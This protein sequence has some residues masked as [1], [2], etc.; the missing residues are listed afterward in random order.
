[1]TAQQL[2]FRQVVKTLTLED[3]KDNLNTIAARFLALWC[4]DSEAAK[5]SLDEMGVDGRLKHMLCVA[6]STVERRR[7]RQLDYEL[8]GM[9]I[10]HGRR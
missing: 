6:I 9:R 2:Q 7:E 1:M 10:R 4:G 8:G 3:I 5:T